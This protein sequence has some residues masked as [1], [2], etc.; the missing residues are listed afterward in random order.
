MK[1]VLPVFAFL[2]LVILSACKTT[3]YTPDKF[4]IRQIVFGGGGGFAGIETSYTLLE[5]GQLF[6]QVGVDGSYTE[7]KS[8]KPKE[9]KVLFDKVNSLQ[10]FKLD[11][12][13]PGNMYYFL[14]QVTDHLDSRVNWGAGDYMPPQGLVSV[15]KELKDLANNREAIISKKSEKAAANSQQKSEEVKPTDDST[16]W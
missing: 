6:K 3:K 16:K 4:P 11:I 7:L 14:R 5:N 15:Y 8:I 1:K 2:S 13:K 10:L 12:D 9:A